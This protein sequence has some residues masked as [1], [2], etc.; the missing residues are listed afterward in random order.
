MPKF[1]RRCSPQPRHA[2]AVSRIARATI[3]PLTLAAFCFFGPTTQG[4][5]ANGN[6]VV[7][8][9]T[10]DNGTSFSVEFD[11]PATSMA[12]PNT[13]RIVGSTSTFNW[14]HLLVVSPT[15]V[16]LL[17]SQSGKGVDQ[18]HELLT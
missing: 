16:V 4:A 3:I 2:S 13:L 1:P 15:G 6:T 18:N 9:V 7:R 17:D 10:C 14:H 8:T 5:L 12:L 11:Q